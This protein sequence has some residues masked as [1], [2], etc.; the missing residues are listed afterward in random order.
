MARLVTLVNRTSKTLEGKWDGRG[1]SIEP[2]KHQFT[3]IMAQKFK[4][5]NPLM[6]SYDPFTNGITYLL[7][8]EENKD[9]CSPLEQS[10]AIELWNRERLGGPPTE[11]V[12]GKGG[13]YA[14]E[15]R[16]PLQN[17][18]SPISTAFAKP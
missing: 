13:L 16:S 11:V 8:I 7:G 9:D 15:R 2:G 10:D 5:Q 12:R 18:N 17:P 6:G 1:Y 14:D 3:E 4:E